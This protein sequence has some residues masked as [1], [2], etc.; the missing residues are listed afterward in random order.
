[1]GGTRKFAP[2]ALAGLVTALALV[3]AAG[4]AHAATLASFTARGSVNQVSVT[5][6]PPGDPLRL[7]HASHPAVAPGTVDDLGSFL[8]RNVAAGDG[9]TVVDGTR[10]STP[11]HVAP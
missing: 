2:V 3:P 8:F 9:Y 7:E 1:M 5:H 6:A 4:T 10:V 11:L